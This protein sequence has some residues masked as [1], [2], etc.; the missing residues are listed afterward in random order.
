M[1]SSSFPVSRRI[2]SPESF[3]SLL[4]SKALCFSLEEP[5]LG[6]RQPPLYPHLTGLGARR[7]ARASQEQRF[8]DVVLW[9][10]PRGDRLRAGGGT[11]ALPVEKPSCAS[12]SPEAPHRKRL[13][14]LPLRPP[15][16][17]SAS[18]LHR[19]NPA[20]SLRRTKLSWW[21]EQ[22]SFPNDLKIIIDTDEK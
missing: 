3:W 20:G 8:L 18:G 13:P 17:A 12:A 5:V 4:K 21:P 7:G 14:C 6:L 16:T 9:A 22:R 11:P 15:L 10:Q 1:L 19:D 2:A